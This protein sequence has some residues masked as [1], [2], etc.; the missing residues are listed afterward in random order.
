MTGNSSPAPSPGDSIGSRS[1]ELMSRLDTALVVVDVQEKLVPAIGG[2]ERLVWN[3][4]RLIDG[5]RLLGLPV[6]AV[7]QYPQGLGPTV[8]PLRERLAS[9][10]VSRVPA[11]QCFSAVGC[12][13]VASALE[14]ANAERALVAGIEAHV[15]VQQTVF[16]LLAGGRRVY[17][18]VDALGSRHEI[19]YETALRRM[20]SAGASLTTVEAALFEW[21]ETS[22]APEFKSLSQLIRQPPL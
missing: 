5:A 4:C 16:D 7:E 1:P 14:A 15:C 18:A 17:V 20:E 12:P 13:E 10:G 19:D 3:L 21:C 22:S 8:A 2:A 6:I 9:A 11:K